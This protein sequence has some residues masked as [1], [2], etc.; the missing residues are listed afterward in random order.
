M[1]KRPGTIPGIMLLAILLFPP[2]FAAAPGYIGLSD[3]ADDLDLDFEWTEAD[4][5][6]RLSR[7]WVRL[8]FKASSRIMELNGVKVFLGDPI[9]F[10]EGHLYLS[11]DDWKYS[12]QPILMPRVFPDP[13]GYRRV[14]IDAG[15]GG[16]DPGGQNQRFGLDEKDFALAVSRSVAQRLKEEGFEVRLTRTGDQF[17]ELEERT[18]IA[19][20][21]KA[22]IFLSIHFNAARESVRGV[23]T[24]IYTL[25]NDPS[26]ARSS[27]DPVDRP[28]YPANAND[29]W[30]ALLGYYLQSEILG[31]TRLPDRGLKRARF[32][33]L[34]GLNSPGALLE[35]GFISNNQ[36]ALLLKKSEYRARLSEAVVNAV[37]KYRRALVRI[38]NE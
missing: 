27:L 23:E 32:T 26:S 11:V 12:I 17:I 21:A 34:E 3:I 7:G 20:Q 1:S 36:T 30:N 38:R 8:D 10:S 19:N 15:H 24:F 14:V 37:L 2:L 29:P 6:A 5:E 4:R 35:L 18:V 16:A 31:T 28:K 9:I 13:P 25:Q 22:D 33:V